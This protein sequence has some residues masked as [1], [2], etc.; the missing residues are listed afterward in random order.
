[1]LDSHLHPCNRGGVCV[2]GAEG[3][4]HQIKMEVFNT[5]F[6]PVKIDSLMGKAGKNHKR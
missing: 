4:W 6:A 3:G 2:F 1:M 5:Y